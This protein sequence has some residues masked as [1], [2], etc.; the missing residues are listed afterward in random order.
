MT[1]LS[2]LGLVNSAN[3]EGVVN[4]IPDGKRRKSFYYGSAIQIESGLYLTAM[5][6]FSGPIEGEWNIIYKKLP[7]ELRICA[8]ALNDGD[9]PRREMI[10]AASRSASA[11]GSCVMPAKPRANS[12]PSGLR[13][14][15][16]TSAIGRL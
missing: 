6:L 7:V 2:L 12:S 15:A 1:P 9:P 4:L 10:R 5:H 13:V 3:P 14:G 8:S 16:R 11:T